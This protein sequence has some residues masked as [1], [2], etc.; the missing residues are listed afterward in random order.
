LITDFF[1][2]LGGGW[3]VAAAGG[4][5]AAGAAGGGTTGCCGGIGPGASAGVIPSSG[6]GLFASCI[7]RFVFSI[8]ET[9]KNKTE[10]GDFAPVGNLS[11]IDLCEEVSQNF[12][13]RIVI[14]GAKFLAK[15][16]KQKAFFRGS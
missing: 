3:P 6:G 1:F 5:T 10:M 4:G 15:L 13:M 8:A 12:A 2:G 9:L 7:P 14:R 11:K 16:T